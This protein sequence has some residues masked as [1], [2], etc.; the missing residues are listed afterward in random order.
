MIALLGL[1]VLIKLTNVVSKD[2][3]EDA[4]QGPSACTCLR[5]SQA[6]GVGVSVRG[7]R[8]RVGALP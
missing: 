1:M 4:R 3:T 8:L 2:L 5:S 6:G 7:G